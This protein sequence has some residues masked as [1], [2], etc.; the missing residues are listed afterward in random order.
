VDVVSRALISRGWSVSAASLGWK[1]K[2]PVTLEG[3]K[4]AEVEAFLAALD[5]DDDVQTIYPGLA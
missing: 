3:E 1:P 4:L 5:D 2:N